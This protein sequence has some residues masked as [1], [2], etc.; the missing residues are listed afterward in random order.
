[1]QTQELTGRALKVTIVL[2]PA[3][4]AALAAPDGQPR[5]VLRVNVGGRVVTAEVTSKSLR[6]AIAVVRET[7]ADG[8]FALL[9]GK[10]GPDD[11]VLEC[12]ILAQVK[13]TKVAAV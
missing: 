3:E 13:T 9:Q 8:C 1:M 2:D 12:G 10:L 7:G 11:A 4:I 6:K 5:V